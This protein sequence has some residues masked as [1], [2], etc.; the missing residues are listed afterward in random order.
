[1]K[2][3]KP[4]TKQVIAI[5]ILVFMIVSLFAFLPEL[6]FSGGNPAYGYSDAVSA[7]SAIV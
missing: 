2:G 5:V 1:M 3:I 7:V 6:L 4:R